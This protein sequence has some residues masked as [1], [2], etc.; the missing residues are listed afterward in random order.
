V[1]DVHPNPE[2][3]AA[4]AEGTL[5]TA[6][7]MAVLEHL[8][9]CEGC[10]EEVF[11]ANAAMREERAARSRGPR[12]PLAAAAA[13]LLV[14]VAALVVPHRRHDV[15]RL[16]A[17]A[18]RD[19]RLVEARLCGGFAYA[20][21]RGPVR[22]NGASSDP[23]M[24]KLVGAAGDLAERADHDRSAEAQHAAGV[25]MLLADRASDA[26][27]RLRDATQQSPNDAAAWSDLAAAE[28]A[29]ALH[30]GRASLYP[31]ALADADRA[32]R[33]DPHRAEALFNRALILERLG[34][35]PQAGAAWQQYLAV[36]ASSDWAT[37]ARAHLARLPEQRG[38]AQFKRELPRLEQAVA[39]DDVATVRQ[40]VA[41]W[42]QQSRAWVEGQW[43]GLWGEA[44]LHGDASRAASQL[45]RC[46]VVSRAVAAP[47]LV[48]VVAGI[49]AAPD[50]D[51]LRLAAAAAQYRAARIAY[52][53]ARPREADP[54]LRAAAAELESLGNPLAIEARYYAACTR[55][56]RGEVDGARE[57]LEALL[58]RAAAYPAAKAQIEWELGL[59]AMT[60]GDWSAALP[61]LTDSAS[62]FA[63]LGE[64]SNA[65]FVDSLRA[66]TLAVLGRR[67]ES[68]SARVASLATLAIEGRDTRLA[69]CLGAASRDELLIGRFAAARALLRL[70]EEADRAAGN[71]PLV[72]DA[73]A[74][75]AVLAARLGDAD[76]ARHA[77]A[78]SA[79]VA[80][81]IADAA[82]RARAVADVDFASG[83]V[84]GDPA[85]LT[86]A[87]DA[88]RSRDLPLYLPEALL[89]RAR[90]ARTWHDDEAAR[91]DLDAAIATIEQRPSELAGTGVLDARNAVYEEAIALALDHHDVNAAFAY[92]EHAR[93]AA[94][95]VDAHTVQR[96]LASSDAA[97]LELIALPH[98]VVAIAVTHDAIAAARKPVAREELATLIALLRTTLAQARELIIV[99]APPLDGVS[100]ASLYDEQRK[101][102]LVEDFALAIAPSA[103]SLVARADAASPRGA[104]AVALPSGETSAA[105][106]DAEA[107]AAG[108]RGIY[109]ATSEL[110]PD[111]ATFSAFV[112]AAADADIVH[113]AGHTS[114]ENG[115]PDDALVFR[116]RRVTWPA[117]AALHLDRA[118]VVVLAAC[119]TLRVPHDRG[120]HALSLAA[121]FAAA[122]AHN[123]IGTLAPI[124]D[125]DAREL[126]NDFHR[127]LAS[128]VAPAEALRQTQLRAISARASEAWR[129]LQMITTS[130]PG[131]ET[132]R[133]PSSSLGS[134][135]TSTSAGRKTS[136]TS[137][138]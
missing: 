5:P 93:S 113:I 63:R 50:A 51:R 60:S 92:A 61:P 103:S 123:V 28:Y 96:R 112:S 38:D 137:A 11:D 4:F 85:A 70:E 86:R 14:I 130:I 119:E 54:Q 90:A 76:G 45:A 56:D 7:R 57:E 37:E 1:T 2:T 84:S 67:D 115:A 98:E 62:I 41:A 58:P 17:L 23:A 66:D 110:P 83:A 126:F 95:A 121:G 124:A 26:V 69:V 43:L 101:R 34:L 111:R 39:A 125:R 105:L 32:L 21:Y 33:L 97:V 107:E 6:E 13:L 71:E 106:P 108:L 82:L 40:I 52:S 47:L 88:Y 134:A 79:I 65:A 133:S 114:R 102:Y 12:W 131:G 35:A 22:A 138:G 75:E 27:T 20:P 136:R 19:Q 104:L 64:R 44:L 129:S 99:A 109:A 117:I 132:W 31:Q 10:R 116:G 55:F 36:D 74:R 25:G 73:L 118:R 68:W 81:H 59:C 91:R 9:H 16:A 78:E 127:R 18:P 53:R 87:I 42:P 48:Q 89:L 80:N 29:D 135:R 72:A 46:R 77:V 49:D 3:I 128:G 24:M 120:T 122:G 8:D 100:F 15:S 30:S 94:N